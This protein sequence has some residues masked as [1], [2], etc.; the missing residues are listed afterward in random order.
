MPQ[1]FTTSNF[2][3]IAAKLKSDFEASSRKFDESMGKLKGN[4]EA[5]NKKFNADLEA[6][7]PRK[8]KVRANT[9]SSGKWILAR[10]VWGWLYHD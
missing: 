6:L 5:T 7:S 2:D 9:N 4:F 10:K 3:E 1:H 8:T